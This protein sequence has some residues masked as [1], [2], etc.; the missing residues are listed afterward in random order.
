MTDKVQ[1]ERHSHG[2]SHGMHRLSEEDVR[3]IR[4]RYAAGGVSQT[5]IAREY[6]VDQSHVSEIIRRVRWKHVI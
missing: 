6:G 5:T 3:A 2:E 4:L 1:K